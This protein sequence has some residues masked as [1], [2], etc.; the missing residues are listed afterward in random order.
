MPA[1]GEQVAAFRLQQRAAALRACAGD[2]RIHCGALSPAPAR[3]CRRDRG[4]AAYGAA[5]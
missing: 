1:G 3:R 5:E 4:E 2:D